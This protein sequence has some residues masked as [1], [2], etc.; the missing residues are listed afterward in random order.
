MNFLKRVILLA[1]ILAALS[2]SAQQAGEIQG[3]V[4]DQS[5]AVIPKAH[6]LLIDIETLQTWQMD[7]S[8]NGAFDFRDLP[9]G[10]YELRAAFRPVFLPYGKQIRLKSSRITTI[11]VVLKVDPRTKVVE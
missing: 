4:E 3:V 6:L 5:G 11:R 9:L 1:V 10:S 7:A 8:N 2:A